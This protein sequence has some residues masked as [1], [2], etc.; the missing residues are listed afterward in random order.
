MLIKIIFLLAALKLHDVQEK[1]MPPTILYTLA[2]MVAALLSSASIF[3]SLIM[4]V[5]IFCVSLV[6]FTLLSRFSDDWR[7][8]G[9]MVG[10]GAFLVFVL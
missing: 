7:Y 3:G 2:Y 8:Y 5:I 4:G 10:G 1:P 6:Y 9:V